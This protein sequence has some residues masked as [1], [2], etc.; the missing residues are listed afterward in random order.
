MSIEIQTED[1]IRQI[2]TI[3]FS[4]KR[5]ILQTTLAFA[6]IT[7]GVAF[8][9]PPVYN[10]QGQIMIRGKKVE[11]SPEAL[12]DTQI[13]AVELTREDLNTEIRI[14]ESKEVLQNT[15]VA[16][17][18]KGLMFGDL[19]LEGQPFTQQVKRLQRNLETELLP[20]S[21]VLG[22]ALAGDN[23]DSLLLILNTL[24][25]QYILYRSELSKTGA[26]ESFY[27]RETDNFR[28]RM[29]EKE[30][31][32]IRIAKDAGT[33]DPSQEIR[34]NDQLRQDIGK[35]LD[36]LEN[37]SIELRGQV[38]ALDQAMQSDDIRFY[39][40]VDNLSI[41]DLGGKLQDLF[42]ERGTLARVYSPKSNKLLHVD[43]QLTESF[44][45]LKAE[46]Q[47][48]RSD[49]QV[50]LDAVTAKMA[51]LRQRLDAL[52]RRNIDLYVLSIEHQRVQRDLDL[53]KHSYEIFSMRL[54]EA[55][56]NNR[57][58]A[59][60]L[61][62]ISILSKPSFSGQPVFPRKS[63]FIPIGILAGLFTGVSL[64]FLREY[65]DHTFKGPE[66]SAKYAGLKTIFSIPRW[67][68]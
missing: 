8:F 20:S 51:S 7:L 37:Q 57:S 39:G 30:Q 10:V 67:E 49:M 24:F 36:S 59:N 68:E 13:R 44:I 25:E 31:E 28:D 58:D 14:V 46:V 43:Q 11:K 32:L 12:E 18:T 27:G 2:V 50:R 3:L 23:P 35:S 47:D 45:A 4:Q 56:I 21:N 65:F 38:E 62:A 17:K 60:S 63:T 33:P 66:D 61:F 55:R 15:I 5:I 34:N 1:Y 19:P 9:F 64:A 29:M 6:L 54:G 52:S 40:F 48:Y 26:V 42:I 16:L 53:L 22:V 41:K